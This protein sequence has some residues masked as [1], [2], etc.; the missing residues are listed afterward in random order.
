MRF[1]CAKP[2]FVTVFRPYRSDEHCMGARDL[3]SIRETEGYEGLG[4]R[5]KTRCCA[6]DSINYQ[7]RQLQ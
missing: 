6:N 2:T 1:R 4:M 7:R 5:H 3:E